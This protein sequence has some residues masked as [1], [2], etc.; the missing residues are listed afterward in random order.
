MS[1]EEI[2]KVSIAKKIIEFWYIIE[3]LSQEEFP[4]ITRMQRENSDLAILMAQDLKIPKGKFKPKKFDIF[5]EL[6]S[7]KQIGQLIEAD[8]LLY[9]KHEYTSNCVHVCYGKLKKEI[10]IKKLFEV[11]KI[12]DNRP[13]LDKGT[14]CLFTLKIDKS[15]FYIKESLRISPMLWGLYRCCIDKNSKNH[16]INRDNYFDDILNIEEIIEEEYEI[17]SEVLSELYENIVNEYVVEILDSMDGLENKGIMIYSRYDSEETLEKNIEKEV[18]VSDLLKG[19]YIDD[20]DMIGNLIE[21][22]GTQGMQA[23]IVDYITGLYMEENDIYDKSSK[24]IDIRRNKEHISRIVD[25]KEAPIGKWP[26][27]YSP[28]FMQQVAVN[29]GGFSSDGVG[30]IFSVNGPPGTGKTTLLKEIIA[31]NIVKRATLLAEYE[32]SDDAF[33]KEYYLDGNFRENGYDKYY[34]CFNSFKDD[35]LSNYGML[36]ASNNNAAVENI[37]KELPD[38]KSLVK[39]IYPNE[40]NTENDRWLEEIAESFDISKS[41]DKEE[42]IIKKGESVCKNDIYFSWPAHKLIYNNNDDIDS[43]INTWGLISAPLGKSSNIAKY[44]HAS[45][46]VVVESLLKCNEI[47]EKRKENYKDARINFLRQLKKVNEIQNDLMESSNLKNEHEISL[48]KMQKEISNCE[49]KLVNIDERLAINRDTIKALEVNIRCEEEKKTEI[50]KKIK[51]KDKDKENLEEHLRI[52]DNDLLKMQ[53][54]IIEQ[55][56]ARKFYEILFGR[57]IKT[58]R[59]LLIESMKSEKRELVKVYESNRKIEKSIIKDKKL[60]EENQNNIK[61]EISKFQEIISKTKEKRA[62]ILSEKESCKSSIEELCRK[63]D[64]TNIEYGARLEK[65]KKGRVVI[66]DN[67]WEE[68]FSS[69]EDISTNAQ[70]A[71]PWSTDKYNREREKLFYLA[72]KL[73]K[74]F[75]LSSKSCRDN[76]I[77]LLM[78]WKNRKNSIG[79]YCNF[80]SRDRERS[81]EHLINTLFLFTPVI[82]TTF[83]S[84]GRFL[85]DIKKPEKIGMLIIDE[86]GQAPPHIALGALWRSKKAIIVGDPKQVEPVVTDDSN[87]IKKAFSDEILR[88]YMDKTISVQ[89]FADRINIYGAYMENSSE[90]IFDWIGCPLVVHRRCIEPMFSI[91]NTISYGG[92]MKCKTQKPSEKVSSKFLLEKSCWLDIK[93][94]EVGNKNHFVREQGYE[95]V[96]MIVESF[97]KYDGYPNL[98]VISPFTT[99]I[100]ELKK[101]VL[102]NKKLIESYGELV[103]KWCENCC[104][105][106]HKFQGKESNEVIFLLGCDNNATGAVNWVKSNILNVAV[107]R[108]KYRIYIVGDSKLWTKSEIFRVAYDLIQ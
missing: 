86:A 48:R 88:P 44:C 92:T 25:I 81:F 100:M 54:S 102:A 16:G 7:N 20:L 99:V 8:D 29:F 19:F 41:I 14:V 106:V 33:N 61:K 13:E 51:E 83:A 75:I 64:L 56:D 62:V 3:F 76:L 35:R 105:T 89:S 98:Y 28:A 70:I 77:N 84:V 91:S 101:M 2:N 68:Y 74:E 94:S 80:S 27:K 66:D 95:T 50:Y 52:L 90:N 43:E 96:K 107:T 15:G 65:I 57:W 82:S 23:D 72:L 26:S 5:K 108:A 37:S 58:E 1:L 97:K 60:L 78:M 55:E 10:I 39:N 71:N 22:N 47:R 63:I 24:R 4:K 11:L 18:D 36:V 104:G 73:H 32:T 30:N 34:Y 12:E 40:I 42:F 17:T 59:V 38:A 9:S 31:D 21:D 49:Y 6:D 85:K 53:R 93:G 87:A 45:L 103:E 46:K 69:N 67:F 79:E